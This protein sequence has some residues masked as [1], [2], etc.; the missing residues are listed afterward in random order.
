M[1]EFAAD[2]ILVLVDVMP[3]GELAKSAAGLLGAAAGVGTP[4][5]PRLYMPERSKQQARRLPA[6]SMSQAVAMR[7]TRLAN[8]SSE[9]SRCRPSLSSA[10]PAGVKSARCPE[11]SNSSTSRPSSS[12]RMEYVTAEGT[13]PSSRAALAKLPW[14]AMASTRTRSSGVMGCMEFWSIVWIQII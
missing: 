2:P 1:T 8:S 11:R 13:L 7:L 4:I 12:L 3:S 14:R 9:C 10:S 6:A 5:A